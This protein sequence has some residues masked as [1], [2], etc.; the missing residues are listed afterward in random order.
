[1]NIISIGASMFIEWMILVCLKSY[2]V[3]SWPML[4]ADM[5]APVYISKM[6]SRGTFSNNLDNSSINVDSWE[7][8]ARDRS[9]WRTAINNS[10]QV[11]QEAYKSVIP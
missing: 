1:M 11:S 7:S 6:S 2:F 10:C 5:V 4:P 9:N 3:V 8:L